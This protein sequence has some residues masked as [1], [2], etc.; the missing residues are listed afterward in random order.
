MLKLIKHE[1]YE[2]K[3]SIEHFKYHLKTKSL[4]FLH[5]SIQCESQIGYVKAEYDIGLIVQVEHVI[6]MKSK[7]L[8]CK[9]QDSNHVIL[10]SSYWW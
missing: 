1:F 6:Y 7:K 3:L 10:D 9:K 2:K 8:P 5:Y 4:K